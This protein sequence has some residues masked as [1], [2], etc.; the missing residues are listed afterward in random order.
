ML[1]TSCSWSPASGPAATFGSSTGTPCWRIGAVTMKMM[2]STSI[3]STSGVTLICE[4]ESLPDEPE[5]N[6]MVTRGSLQEVTFGDVEEFGRERVHL[7]GQ[8]ADLARKPVEQHDGGNRRGEPHRRRD[9]RL[10]DPGRD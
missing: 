10:R 1:T 5:S 3:T 2:S 6:A 8:H 4:M 9:E 7:G